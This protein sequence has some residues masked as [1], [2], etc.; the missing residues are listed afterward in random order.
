MNSP[1][2]PAEA[3][4]A[5]VLCLALY[6]VRLTSRDIRIE[7]SRHQNVSRKR[8]DITVQTVRGNSDT[9]MLEALRDTDL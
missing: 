8:A 9:N 3:T 4:N 7:L 5:I 2:E 1:D 6:F